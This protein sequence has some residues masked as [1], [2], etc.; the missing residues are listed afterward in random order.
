MG[1]SESATKNLTSGGHTACSTPARPDLDPPTSLR[2]PSFRTQFIPVI[3]IASGAVIAIGSVAPWISEDSVGVRSAFQLGTKYG[4]TFAGPLT[5]LLLGI[6]TVVIGIAALPPSPLSH[7]LQRSSIV[8]GVA[9]GVVLLNRLPGLQDM[10]KQLNR[11]YVIN[12]GSASIGFGYWMCGAG[13]LL[14]VIAG[15]ALPRR[16]VVE[17]SDDALTSS[18]PLEKS[19]IQTSLS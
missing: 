6:L 14:A 1:V 15:I 5:T 10:A 13:A 16:Q 3:V 2:D 4:L 12:G 19:P 7:L 11:V 9:E 8:T 18:D 17:K